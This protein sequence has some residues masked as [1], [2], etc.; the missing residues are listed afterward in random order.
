[1]NVAVF[2]TVQFSTDLHHYLWSTL[3]F[4]VIVLYFSSFH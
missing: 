3:L 1:M 4:L 2:P